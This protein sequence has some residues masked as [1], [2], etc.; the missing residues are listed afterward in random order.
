MAFFAEGGNT[1]GNGE[2]E[3]LGAVFEKAAKRLFQSGSLGVGTELRADIN[4]GWAF[5][6]T[7]RAGVALG[8]LDRGVVPGELTPELYFAFGSSL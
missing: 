7:L 6:L 8:V 5:P 1:F 4:F 3:D 2:E